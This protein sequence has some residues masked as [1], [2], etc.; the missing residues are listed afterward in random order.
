MP[1]MGMFGCMIV[2]LGLEQCCGRNGHIE[3]S[4]ET[5]S[6]VSINLA[7]VNYLIFCHAVVVSIYFYTAELFRTS[8]IH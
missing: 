4:D 3:T 5:R 6:A 2:F 8:D 1:Q 7:Y